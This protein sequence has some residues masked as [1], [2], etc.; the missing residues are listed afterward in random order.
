VSALDTGEEKPPWSRPKKLKVALIIAI[1]VA[2]GTVVWFRMSY[3]YGPSHCCAAE[4]GTNLV[5]YAGDHEGWFPRGAISPEASFGLLH[6]NY[7]PNLQRLRGK[8]VPLATAETAWQQKGQLDAESCGWHYVEG[9]SA[10]NDATI[11]IGWDKSWGLG[12]NGQRIRKFGREVIYLNSSTEAKLINDWPKFAMEQR[13]KLAKIIAARGT[14]GPPIRW[15]D[16]ETLGTNWFPRP[17]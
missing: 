7:E 9:L 17:K 11:A 13:E 12:H 10:T 6:T 16:E 8:I 4:L 14:N 1:T 5:R 2:I 15:S 3:P